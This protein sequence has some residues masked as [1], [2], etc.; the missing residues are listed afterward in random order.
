[1]SEDFKFAERERFRLTPLS[2]IHTGS[3]EDFDWTTCV[4]DRARGELVVFD[5]FSVKF[6]PP[7]RAQIARLAE[8]SLGVEG[9]VVRLVVEFQQFLKKEVA[10]IRQSDV[11]S[12]PVAPRL[13]AELDRK[14]GSNRIV[15]NRDT[16][17]SLA[18]ARCA[19]DPRSGHPV[20]FGSALKGAFRTAWIDRVF[21][22]DEKEMG[23]FDT[24]PFSRVAVEDFMSS[25]G[26]W[27]AIVQAANIK[28][29]GVRRS[30][31]PKVQVEVVTPGPN[32]VF[33]GA[34]RTRRRD[35]KPG[36]PELRP[37][38]SE[39]R[40]FHHDHWR[41]FRP[42]MDGR[43][44]AWW[45]DSMDALVA[46]IEKTP[47]ASLVRLGKFCG[48]EGKTTSA[49]SIR[50]RVSR[51]SHETRRE[52]TTLWLANDDGDAQGLPFGWALLEPLTDERLGDTVTNSFAQSEFWAGLRMRSD[53]KHIT[54]PIGPKLEK[55]A[56]APQP[57]TPGGVIVADLSRRL[58]AKSLSE[59]LM[60]AAIREASGL[61]DPEDRL[62]VKVWLD[63][64]HQDVIRAPYRRAEFVRVHLAKLR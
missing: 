8:Q 5:G 29:E 54:S 7:Q 9:D 13:L 25:A 26:A 36:D 27:T 24:D 2:P 19:A 17:Q 4:L 34:L 20:I 60:K 59:D 62:L 22:R 47:M 28:R 32:C 42:M 12:Y 10:A 56:A 41:R 14:T 61:A 51:D 16:L 21:P 55:P 33:H 40:R 52:G 15:G 46:A 6:G 11:R 1:M 3:G 39:A 37:L 58:E 30:P 35:G 49:R 63:Q 50:V 45:L 48:A 44:E 53:E 43:A 18:I 23:S 38:L 64:H 31:G 57:A